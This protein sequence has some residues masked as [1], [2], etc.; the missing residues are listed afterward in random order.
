[1]HD[2][3]VLTDLNKGDD[4]AIVDNIICPYSVWLMDYFKFAQ[5]INNFVIN[6]VLNNY[7]KLE[8]GGAVERSEIQSYFWSRR[9]NSIIWKDSPQTN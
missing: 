1:M 4:F 5:T 2:T 9:D 6:A 3:I 8:H 7:D